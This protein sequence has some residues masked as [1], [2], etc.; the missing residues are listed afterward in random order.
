[1]IIARDRRQAR[2]IKAFCLG[3]IARSRHAAADP[4]RAA[5]EYGAQF[6]IDMDGR[7]SGLDSGEHLNIYEPFLAYGL[8][9]HSSMELT[10]R[11]FRRKLYKCAA[12]Q[13][14]WNVSLF[15]IRRTSPSVIL[16]AALVAIRSPW[17]L[18]IWTTPNKQQS[19][20]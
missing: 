16:L 9:A 1:M 20:I 3:A 5:A 13:R 18:G 8:L 12:F 7:H 6:K 15:L 11:L 19:L 4:A 14:S 10:R 17:Q 2:V